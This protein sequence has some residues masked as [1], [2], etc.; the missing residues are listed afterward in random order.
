MGVRELLIESPNLAG[1]NPIMGEKLAD[2]FIR[3]YEM[4]LKDSDSVYQMV[5]GIEP[6]ERFNPFSDLLMKF[7]GDIDVIEYMVNLLA[8][9]QYI[10]YVG[11]GED[12]SE[13][14]AVVEANVVL[15]RKV[16]ADSVVAEVDAVY[17]V[18]SAGWNG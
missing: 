16:V 10:V 15:S 12:F 9:N 6:T 18:E 2:E 17:G 4:E 3:M 8:L 14:L 7:G 13:E 1:C 11:R 5:Y